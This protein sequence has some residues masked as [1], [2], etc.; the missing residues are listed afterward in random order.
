MCRRA[1]MLGLLALTAVPAAA[2]ADGPV[3]DSVQSAPAERAM[4]RVMHRAVVAF[5]HVQCG[6][7]AILLGDFVDADVV[8][9]AD[10]IGCSIYL[11]AAAFARMPKAMVCSLVLHEYGHLAGHA[12]SDDPG[13]VMYRFYVGPDPRCIATG[14][15]ASHSYERELHDVSARTHSLRCPF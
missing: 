15:Y 3:L 8:A 7:P 13:S 12:D 9:G 6:A 2:R 5:G 10:P 14:S 11:N 1:L 4:P